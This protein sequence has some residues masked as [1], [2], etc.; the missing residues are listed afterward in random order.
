MA[1]KH[2]LTFN[3]SLNKVLG[4]TMADTDNATAERN[5][6]NDAESMLE[7]I[8]ESYQALKA[9]T[10]GFVVTKTKADDSPTVNYYVSITTEAQKPN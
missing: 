8:L 1:G 4:I 2:R 10:L 5:A 3:Q 6:A 9:H 7:Q